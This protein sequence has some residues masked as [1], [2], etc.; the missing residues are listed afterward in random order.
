MSERLPRWKCFRAYGVHTKTVVTRPVMQ[1]AGQ[2]ST[3]ALDSSCRHAGRRVA[4]GWPGVV[5]GGLLR[6]RGDLQTRAL[7]GEKVLNL[8][9]V[10]REGMFMQEDSGYGLR[11]SRSRV[12]L[13]MHQPEKG[14]DV[15]VVVEAKR[16]FFSAYGSLGP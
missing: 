15:L 14:L 1:A 13:L 11:E 16:G 10:R 4:D 3:A 7:R 9:Q 2:L 6:L 12:L 8:M 5:K